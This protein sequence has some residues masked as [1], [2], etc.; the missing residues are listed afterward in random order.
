M[1]LY[2][3]SATEALSKFKNKTLS[4]VELIKAVIDRS[5]K[6]NSKINA[7]NFTF[8]EEAILNSKKSENKY[9]SNN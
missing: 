3:L 5:E 2:Y 7:H 1:E 6:I 8:Y 9:F 4:P